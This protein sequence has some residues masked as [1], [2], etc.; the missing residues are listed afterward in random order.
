MKILFEFTRIS[1]EKSNSL[2]EKLEGEGHIQEAV[3]MGC[4]FWFTGRCAYNWGAYKQ[5]FTVCT[6]VY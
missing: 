2:Q 4:L 1:H 6:T 5:K 3:I